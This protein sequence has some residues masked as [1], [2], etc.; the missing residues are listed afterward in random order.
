MWNG[1]VT[2]E[3]KQLHEQYYEKYEMEPDWYAEIFY[4]GMSYEEYLGY[5]REC[6]GKGLEIPDVVK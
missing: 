2:E 3:L 1:K 5:I 6:L 4:A